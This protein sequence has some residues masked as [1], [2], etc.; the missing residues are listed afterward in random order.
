MGSQF[1]FYDYVDSDGRNGIRAFLQGLDR[2][3]RAK[4]NK[5]LLA[6]SG[7]RIEDW[8]WPLVGLLTD[9][10]AG[11]FEIRV[12]LQR[13]HHRI[14]G[15]HLGEQGKATLLYGFTKRSRRVGEADCDRA[16]LRRN[17]VLTEIETRRLEHRYD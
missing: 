5:N 16:L 9:H 11:L 4:F 17:E 1:T 6:L 8:G 14:L 10:C 3:P 12:S 2:K 7:L 15:S 13:V